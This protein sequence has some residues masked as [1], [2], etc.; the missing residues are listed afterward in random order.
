MLLSWE[1][2]SIGCKYVTTRDSTPSKTVSPNVVNVLG[3]LQVKDVKLVQFKKQ[4]NFKVVNVDGM[5]ILFN[6]K[7]PLKHRLP[8]I[9]IVDVDNVIVCNAV[10]YRKQLLGKLVIKLGIEIDVK[11]EQ[12]SKQL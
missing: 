2:F 1:K 3:S 6:A 7:H 5:V 4:L 8:I 9:D 10:Q 12:Y 11:L